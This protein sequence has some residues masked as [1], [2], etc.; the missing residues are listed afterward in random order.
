MEDSAALEGLLLSQE[1]VHT[2]AMGAGVAI[3]HA[4]MAGLD[5]PALMV[6]LAP[7]GTDFGPTGLDPVHL[8]FLLL[9]PEDQM[10]LH[11]KLLARITR[12]IRHPGFIERLRSARSSTELIEEFERVDADHV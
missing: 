4:T 8:F 12:L 9:S 11:I 1:A 10:G 6:A 3:P 5:Y 2:T 7:G